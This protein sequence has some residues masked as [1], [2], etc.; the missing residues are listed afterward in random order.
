MN[1]LEIMPGISDHDTVFI[2]TNIEPQRQRPVKRKLYIWKQANSEKI[3]EELDA[4]SVNFRKE[5]NV[6]S[7][8]QD[9]WDSFKQV[10]HKM[11]NDYVP[12]KLSSTRFNQ[13]WINRTVKSLSQKKRRQWKRARKSSK[14]SDCARFKALQKQQKKVC[15]SAYNSYISN[16][17]APDLKAK[18]KKFW[19]FIKSKRH[20]TVGVSP[21]RAAN[22]ITYSDDKTKSDIL[23]G[24]F[25]PRGAF[26]RYAYGGV[27]PRNFQATQ[28]YHISF[29]ATQKYHLILY[30]E[31]S[32]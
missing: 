12:S 4:Y 16:M 19:Q 7:A 3:R 11:I 15:R 10:C 2:N 32:K 27:S 17:A 21:I 8:V 25:K 29:T 26:S 9:M 28:K 24:T 13:P 1:R 14:E 22:R 31:T 30:L 20:D 5:F 18:P 6:N 23:N